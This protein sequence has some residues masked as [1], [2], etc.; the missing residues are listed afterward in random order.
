M[1]CVGRDDA[2]IAAS[3]TEG[4]IAGTLDPT[5]ISGE[6]AQRPLGPGGEQDEVNLLGARYC[7]LFVSESTTLTTRASVGGT[8]MSK[9]ITGQST[10][11]VKID[12]KASGA[13]AEAG[14]GR[15]E[16]TR[17]LH[18]PRRRLRLEVQGDA[19]LGQPVMR[20][21]ADQAGR[22]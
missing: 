10:S 22:A 11:A 13:P 12:V 2:S 1:A 21:I 18:D 3:F 14:R 8:P 5:R 19:H 4:P 6:A 20:R 16:R 15:R 9:D 7:G 17:H